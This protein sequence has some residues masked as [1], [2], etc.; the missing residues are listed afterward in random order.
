[1]VSLCYARRMALKSHQLDRGLRFLTKGSRKRLR[2]DM[3]KQL[4]KLRRSLEAAGEEPGRLT[5]GYAS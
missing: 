3:K 1:M 5:K 2:R 4:A